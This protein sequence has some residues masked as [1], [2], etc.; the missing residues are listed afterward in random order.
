MADVLLRAAEPGDQATIRRIIRAARLNP[1]ALDWPR[2]LIAED[3]GQIVGIGQIKV[4]GDGTRELASLAVA[5]SYQGTG[6]GGVLVWT[7]I[8]L[9]PGPLYLRCA[10]HNEGFYQRFGFRTLAPEQMPRSLHSAY[11]IVNSLVKPLN[12]ITGGNE[13]MLIMGR[14]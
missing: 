14:L 10:T 6:I 9:A 11:R 4:L 12:F 2:F 1:M 7:L 13:R 5:P 8:S 3:H